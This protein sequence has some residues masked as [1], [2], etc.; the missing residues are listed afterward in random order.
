MTQ[1][2]KIK[3]TYIKPLTPA[4]TGG[5]PYVRV[6]LAA[7]ATGLGVSLIKRIGGTRRFGNADYISVHAVNA[8]IAGGTQSDSPKT[9]HE[10]GPSPHLSKTE[11]KT[12]FLAHLEGDS[13][14]AAVLKKAA[15]EGLPSAGT[16]GSETSNPTTPRSQENPPSISP[17]GTAQPIADAD[18]AGKILPS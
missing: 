11:P 17:I 14:C 9:S 4:E 1:K 18:N 8:F 15:T 16:E 13:E 12:P 7:E 3:A 2:T 10:I 6:T 5:A